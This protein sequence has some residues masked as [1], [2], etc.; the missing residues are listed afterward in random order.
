MAATFRKI[1]VPHQHEKVFSGQ[2]VTISAQV[3]DAGLVERLITPTSPPTIS[4]YD[5]LGILRINDQEMTY[6]RNGHYSLS[7]TTPA[8][9]GVYTGSFSA[10]YVQDVARIDRVALFKVIKLSDFAD[11]SYLVIADQTG[12]LW[13]LWVDIAK[14]IVTSPTVP[15]FLAKDVISLYED[16]IYW[17]HMLNS[18]SQLV[19]ILPDVTGSLFDS[20]SQPAVGTGVEGSPTW[21]GFDGGNYILTLD[22][23]NQITVVEV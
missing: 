15:S 8:I 16:P 12:K 17:M 2:T 5:P 22:M 1:M 7:Y 13:Y 19:Y 23:L 10:Q 11:I 20:V 6:V 18:D 14:Q 21:I 3:M 4:I 9:M